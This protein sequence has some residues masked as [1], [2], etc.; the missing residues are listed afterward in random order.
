MSKHTAVIAAVVVLVLVVLAIGASKPPSV[1]GAW[2]VDARHSDAQLIT[3]G[4]TDNGKT[5]ID[6]TVGIARVEGAMNIDD[7]D[8]SKSRVDLH[9]Y[10]ATSMLPAIGEEGDLKSRWLANMANHT[11][12]CFHSKNVTRT[13]DGRLQSKGDLILVRVDRN[14]EV[15]PNEGYAG[16]VY[17]EPM[18]HRVS[19]PATF[20]FD[21]PAGVTAQKDG[22]QLS[23]ST[24]V[25]REDFPQLVKAVLN[26]YWPPVVQD[27]K[28]NPPSGPSEAYSGVKCTGTVLQIPRIPDNPA[29]HVG[30]DY[31][32][33]QDFNS[34]VGGAGEYRAS[35]A[36]ASRWWHDARDGGQLGFVVIFEDC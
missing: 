36:P 31:P 27:E 28:C 21:A 19:Q 30:E 23:G 12:L 11:M 13:A 8:S 14:V 22:L 1:A 16:P 7:A 10:P 35:R 9:I 32:G 34:V 18:I 3:D 2:Q 25:F 17:G 29:T 33:P 24:K 26:T 15:T 4:T 6:V 20:V 5:K